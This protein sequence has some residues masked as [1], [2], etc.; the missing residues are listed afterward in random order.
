MSEYP[1]SRTISLCILAV[2]L[3]VLPHYVRAAQGEKA[4]KLTLKIA[5]Q[6][7]GTALQELAR[8]SGVQIVFFF[9]NHR[10]SAGGGTRRG[11]RTDRGGA[12]A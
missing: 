7:L 3:A 10:G 1:R 2:T 8:Q 12:S 4:A 9:T 6:S 5:P 11:L